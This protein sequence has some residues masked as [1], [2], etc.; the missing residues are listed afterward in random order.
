[1]DA[2]DEEVAARQ[3]SNARPGAFFY[4]VTPMS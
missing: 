4:E 2:L 1:L 3:R